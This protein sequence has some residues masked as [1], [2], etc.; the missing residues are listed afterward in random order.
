MSQFQ[1]RKNVLITGAS[2][3]IG[4]ELSKVF[5]EHDHNLILTARSEQKLNQLAQEL[6]Q[7]Y[8]LDSKVLVRDLSEPNAPNEIFETLQKDG[9]SV[10]ILVN[11]AGFGTYGYFAELDLNKEL[12]MMQVNMT[13]LTHL[14][15]LFMSG[16][17]KRKFGRILNVGSRL[18]FQAVP[19]MAVYSASKAYVLSFS[20]A[21]ASELKGTGVMV[22]VLCPGITT[23]AFHDKAHFKIPN[24]LQRSSMSARDVAE[25]GYRGLMKGQ[26]VVIPGALNTLMTLVSKVSP[27]NLTAHITRTIS[28]NQ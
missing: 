22:T 10:D 6:S 17:V 3:G 28:K 11:N 13:A 2:S 14:T 18:A 4:Y 7:K 19:N 21:I 20:E 27:R 25:I 23:T 1:Q 15:R 5:A 16:M 26:T 9:I 12:Q 8:Q 24:L